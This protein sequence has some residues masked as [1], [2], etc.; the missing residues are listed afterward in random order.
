MFIPEMKQKHNNSMLQPHILPRPVLTT[1][2]VNETI[3]QI[4]NNQ[5]NP[6]KIANPV[7]STSYNNAMNYAPLIWQ[8][9]V[10]LLG[11]NFGLLLTSL[12]NYRSKF[13]FRLLCRDDKIVDIEKSC[14]MN[15]RNSG[16]PLNW[17]KSLLILYCM[18]Q[19]EF[20]MRSKC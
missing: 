17:S 2:I 7:M 11:D 9:C 12:G 8:I 15:R 20:Y 4:T 1:R 19:Y 6:N 16:Q 13:R 14:V 5:F 18:N 10:Q 3:A